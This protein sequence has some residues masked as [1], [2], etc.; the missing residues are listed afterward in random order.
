MVEVVEA[1]VTQV[2]VATSRRPLEII[3]LPF[4]FTSRQCGVLSYENKLKKKTLFWL[5]CGE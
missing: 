5:L 1:R 4:D 3:V 2:L